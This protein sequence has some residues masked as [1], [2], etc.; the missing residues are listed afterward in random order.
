MRG[1]VIILL[2][3]MLSG[4]VGGRWLLLSSCDHIRYE[5]TGNDIEVE[6]QCSA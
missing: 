4:C 5:R 2:A 3:A 1:L 6:A